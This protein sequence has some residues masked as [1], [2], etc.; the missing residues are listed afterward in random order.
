MSK[1]KITGLTKDAGFQMGIRRVIPVAPADAWDF[2]FSEEG[3][4][5]WFGKVKEWE[6]VVLN[7]PFKSA[8][9]HEGV[10]KVVK[11]YSHLRMRFKKKGWD[12]QTTL[13]I[14]VLKAKGGTTLAFHH[15]HLAG[16]EERK[17]MLSHWQ[18][19]L[20]RVSKKLTGQKTSR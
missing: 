3:V 20:T 6:G 11:P 7:E 18:K 14:R 15:D 1:K 9:G 4:A 16:V 10:L 5:M 13:Q 19:V 8:G 17:A 12:H 2:I